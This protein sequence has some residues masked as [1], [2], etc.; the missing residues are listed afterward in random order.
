MGARELERVLR[1]SECATLGLAAVKVG[2]GGIRVGIG[3]SGPP[4][5]RE[6]YG[7]ACTVRSDL[8]L[9]DEWNLPRLNSIEENRNEDSQFTGEMFPF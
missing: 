2:C 8:E 6:R 9:G 7:P 1:I 4:S 3:W 5:E